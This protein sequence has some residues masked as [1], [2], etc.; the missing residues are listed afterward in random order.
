MADY[1]IDVKAKL[2]VQDV[3]NTLSKENFQVKLIPHVDFDLNDSNVITVKNKIDKYFERERTPL[4][5]ALFQEFLNQD[6]QEINKQIAKIDLD[7]INIKT[8]LESDNFEQFKEDIKWINDNLKDVKSK[9]FN[10][11]FTAPTQ[12]E[13]EQL[14]EKINNLKTSL[15][16]PFN[17]NFNINEEDYNKLNE[18]I[19]SVYFLRE[20]G[21]G[22]PVDIDINA[23]EA[24]ALE[25]I[26][27]NLE[28]I[29]SAASTPIDVEIQ[30]SNKEEIQNIS[31]ILSTIKTSLNSVSSKKDGIQ[32]NVSSPSEDNIA[33]IKSTI[34][35]YFVRN[36][37]VLTLSQ[38]TKGIDW[39][40]FNKQLEQFYKDQNI[41][42]S[43]F[44]KE[45]SD[46]QKVAQQKEIEDAKQATIIKKAEEERATLEKKQQLEQQREDNKNALEAQAQDILKYYDELKAKRKNNQIDEEKYINEIKQLVEKTENEKIL[47][48]SS[49][50]ADLRKIRQDLYDSEQALAK[51]QQEE[52]RVRLEKQKQDNENYLQS[53]INNFKN[54]LDQEGKSLQEKLK[55]FDSSV[56]SF[57]LFNKDSVE[58]FQQYIDQLSKIRANFLENTKT[59]WKTA[60]DSV[61]NEFLQN[62]DFKQFKKQFSEL[63]AIGISNNIEGTLDYIK[64]VYNEALKYKK[65]LDGINQATEIWKQRIDEVFNAYVEKRITFDEVTDILKEFKLSGIFNSE[66]IKNSFTEVVN[67][68]TEIENNRINAQKQRQQEEIRLEQEKQEEKTRLAQQGAEEEER[69]KLEAYKVLQNLDAKSQMD[70][71]HA[72]DEE[73]RYAKEYV[74]IA[75]AFN[76]QELENSIK[77]QGEISANKKQNL[78]DLVEASKK[79]SNNIVN[80]EQE[81]SQKASDILD[82]QQFLNDFERWET[83]IQKIVNHFGQFKITLLEARD[84][85]EK[86]KDEGLQSF[87]DDISQVVLKRYYEALNE[88]TTAREQYVKEVEKTFKEQASLLVLSYKNNEKDFKTFQK[89]LKEKIE[90]A[91][92]DGFVSEKTISETKKNLKQI[93]DA[94]NKSNQKITENKE[95]ENRDS[96]KKDLEDTQD[97]YNKKLISAKEYIERMNALL[98]KAFEAGV[99]GAKK[100]Q[101]SVDKVKKELQEAN[102]KTLS[103]SDSLNKFG[104][105]SNNLFNSLMRYFGITQIISSITSSFSKMITEV[106]DLDKELTEFAKVSDLSKEQTEEFID[107]CYELGGAVA[108]TGTEAVT[109]TTLFKKMGYTVEE[110]MQYAKDALMWTNVADGMVSVEEASTMLISTM[111]AFGEE[112]ISTTHIIDALN[113]VSNNYS[114]S[115]SNLSN[116]L[117]TVAATLAASGVEFEEMI[118]LMTAGIEIMPDKASKV[119]NGL[120]TISQRIRQIDGD[121]AAKLDEFLGAK[122]IKRFDE[123]T[124]QLKSTY[125]ILAEISELWPKLTINERQYLGETMAGKNQITVLNAIMTNFKTTLDATATA[126]DSLGSAEQENARVLNSIEGHINNFKKS[127]EELSKDLINS[128]LFKNVVDFGTQIIN[129]ID[130]I[131]KN[132]GPALIRVIVGIGSALAAIQLAKFGLQVS[133]FISTLGTMNPILLGILATIGVVSSAV[134]YLIQDSQ[135]ANKELDELRKL[136]YKSEEEA[137]KKQQETQK[138]IEE[139]LKQYELLNKKRKYVNTQ[140]ERDE[141]NEQL[142]LIDQNLKNQG[143]EVDLVKGKY[144][145][146]IKIIKQKLALEKESYYTTLK[147]KQ[148]EEQKTLDPI[149]GIAEKYHGSNAFTSSLQR[150]VNDEEHEI[151]IAYDNI[152]NIVVEKTDVT[153]KSLEDSAGNLVRMTKDIY[154]RSLQEVLTDTILTSQEKI[155][156]FEKAILDYKR[157][158]EVNAEQAKK[159][160]NDAIGAVY[161]AEAEKYTEYAGALQIV[162]N[163]IENENGKLEEVLDAATESVKAK[164]D[165]MG[166]NLNEYSSEVLQG[167]QSTINDIDTGNL[168]LD[169]I[170]EEYQEFSD[171]LTNDDFRKAFQSLVTT[172]LD[173]AFGRDAQAMEDAAEAGDN[174]SNSIES[175]KVSLSG[176]I[177]MMSDYASQAEIL[178]QAQE[179]ISN[180]GEITAETLKKIADAGL[181]AYLVYDEETKSLVVNTQA[182]MDNNASIEDN[183]IAKH[184]NYEKSKLNA[185]IENILAGNID[186][187]TNSLTDQTGALNAHGEA[188]LA[189]AE[190]T[191]ESVLAQ[192]QEMLLLGEITEDQFYAMQRAAASYRDEI[193]T[194]IEAIRGY[195]GAVTQAQT[196]TSRGASHSSGSNGSGSS[197]SRSSSSSADREAQQAQRE[198]EKALREAQQAFKDGFQSLYNELKTYLDLGAITEKEYYDSL[199]ILVDKFYK[200]REGYEEEYWKYHDEIVKGRKKY[201]EQEMEDLFKKGETVLKRQLDVEVITYEEYFDSLE[202]LYKSYYT[203]K[204]DFENAMWELEK[205]RYEHQ[206]EEFDK[207]IKEYED[208]LSSLFTKGEKLLKHQLEMDELTQEEYLERLEVLYRASITD[209]EELE[210]KLLEIKEERYKLEKKKQE[211]HLK[212]LEKQLEEYYDKVKEMHDEYVKSLEDDAESIDAV[213]SY[214][215][216]VLDDEISKLEEEKKAL[217]EANSALEEQIKL[218]ELEENL[219]KAKNRKIR[220]YRKGQGFV[221][222]EDTKAVSEAQSAIDEYKKELAHKKEISMIDERIKQLQKY[223]EAWSNIPKEYKKAQNE[224]LALQRAGSDAQKKIL[225]GDQAFINE[226]VRQYNTTQDKL[227]EANKRNIDEINNFIFGTKE[228]AGL[229]QKID[230]INAEIERVKSIEIKAL[231]KGGEEGSGDSLEEIIDKIENLTSENGPIAKLNKKKIELQ[232]EWKT[233][234]GE[235][236]YN[237]II[238]NINNIQAELDKIKVKDLNITN[239]C[240]NID[241]MIKKLQDL[242]TAA[243][244]ASNAGIDVGNIGDGTYNP[245]GNNPNGG[246]SGTGWNAGAKVKINSE[247]KKNWPSNWAFRDNNYTV[248]EDDAYNPGNVRIL[249]EGGTGGTVTHSVPASWL[250]GI[251]DVE[252]NNSSEN[253]EVTETGRTPV[254]NYSGGQQ[255]LVGYN[256]TYSDGSSIYMPAH[257]SGTLGTTSK[258]FMVNENGLE[259]MVTPEGTV[260]SAPSTGYGVIKNEYTER[261]TDFAS[262]PMGFLSKAFSGY[263]GT[264]KNNSSTNETININGNLTLPNVTNGESFVDSIRNL[265]LQYTTRRK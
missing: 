105:S 161:E 124:N 127:F 100:F 207:Q 206:I 253:T 240:N 252:N 7:K 188:A 63:G 128:D 39:E 111:K 73:K 38:N 183:A 94:Y 20:E 120:K 244:N 227:S 116:N 172:A 2:N 160:E 66:E 98:P 16:N 162:V 190:K 61:F 26:A 11:K 67:E 257:A 237:T 78:L 37:I 85:L 104:S 143:V 233:V 44:L 217:D 36:P 241:S 178:S 186:E 62:E 87:D 179:D 254:Y 77:T 247:G 168:K 157:M 99:N 56:N 48:T 201:L 136:A 219:Q 113:E 236:Q 35:Q 75:N 164:L 72:L 22:T 131:V 118:G 229:K 194:G 192:A 68:I 102:N 187:S 55:E 58:N 82:D 97:L 191:S 69:I 65:Q 14:Q 184:I 259:A 47:I 148:L 135:E 23:N 223:K 197:S 3:E 140:E 180:V 34:E 52:E 203:D 28:T 255:T 92:K 196:A 12:N 166:I 199:E 10:I 218:Q 126:Y 243:N 214:A 121:T 220:V 175:N 4:R 57:S 150:L 256:V 27:T 208:E 153:F 90:K 158:A 204:E 176:A 146:Q 159:Y 169:E 40:S 177:A 53:Q 84:G 212:E 96:I 155:A 213:I 224:L 149:Q 43:N 225:N 112:S 239:W 189:D 248:V 215:I 250:M 141:L 249:V 262:D 31:S 260:I 226:F 235:S 205:E 222:E 234:N 193:K 91:Q 42:F 30:L 245:S 142:S 110:S 32:I 25:N 76:K 265:A 93:E 210:D 163:N 151:E 130:D 231:I 21:I 18:I 45:Q 238:N 258:T 114:V 33:K 119:A 145:D 24:E 182:F 122:G 29:K 209:Q 167:L 232:A 181:E 15:E 263:S 95:K 64:E 230:Q 13:I 103:F 115:S 139:S 117:S 242:T 123:T 108:K 129:W 89:E 74:D 147:Q 251:N 81:A 134:T 165:S 174:L 246:N 132:H 156:I 70:K 109:A 264:Y 221:Y 50:Q 88:L 1:S 54:L 86:L 71:R 173:V 46:A 200:D 170:P 198:A 202:Q 19:Q 107:A 83:E 5:F 195:F 101:N 80:I 106:R 185:E 125:D 216:D 133:N 79:A 8:N 49:H 41:A 228:G 17:I 137:K 138:S 6:V 171:I 59:Q 261:L 51:Q 144:E 60:V 211:E 154:G 9:T 152:K